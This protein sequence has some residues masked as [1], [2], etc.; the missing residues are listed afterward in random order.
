MQED[1]W[2]S[3]SADSEVRTY[4]TAKNELTGVLTTTPGVA[5]YSIA[6]DPSSRRA[7]VASECVIF[8]PA[9]LHI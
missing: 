5:V 9:F 2:L 1:G 8:C 4:V 7:A 3:G 6:V